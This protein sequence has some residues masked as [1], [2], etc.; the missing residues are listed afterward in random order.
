MP[1]AW[2]LFCT[3]PP[4]WLVNE[5]EAIRAEVPVLQLVVSDEPLTAQTAAAA[6]A[7]RVPA[8]VRQVITTRVDNDDAI[9]RDYLEA[10]RRAAI[11]H[12][13]AF[14]NFTHGLQI[15]GGRLYRRS[16]PS[17]AF[18]SLVEHTSTPKTVFVDQHQLVDRHGPVL[19][20]P[21][22]DMWLQVIHG[23]NVANVARGVRTDPRPIVPRYACRLDVRPVSR[24]LL[25]LDRL[26][27]SGRLALRV[28]RSWDRIRWAWRVIRGR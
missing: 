24:P 22:R 23:A 10:V 4:R 8:E 18:V 3:P 5:F 12:T 21:R 6:V 9:A 14:L 17:N 26:V 27:T 11:D 1:D 15:S 13:Y 19:Q 7:E 2:L 28:I 16:D 25:E 20:I